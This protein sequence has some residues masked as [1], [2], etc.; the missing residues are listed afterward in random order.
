[1]ST[2]RSIEKSNAPE[3]QHGKTVA[4][5]RRFHVAGNQVVHHAHT[6]GGE[7][8][9]E[10]VVS[11]EPADDGIVQTG[12]GYEGTLPDNPDNREPE[13]RAKEIPET[14][15]ELFDLTVDDGHI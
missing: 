3:A 4:I 8:H 5:E 1:M 14:D 6:N 9:A 15:V 12:K 2:G 7:P 11:V 13:E 10:N